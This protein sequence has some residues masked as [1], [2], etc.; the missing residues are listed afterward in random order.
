MKLHIYH[1]SLWVNSWFC[2]HKR[3]GQTGIKSRFGL[4]ALYVYLYT[5]SVLGSWAAE[6][7]CAGSW[8]LAWMDKRSVLSHVSSHHQVFSLACQRCAAVSV[9]T[10]EQLRSLRPVCWALCWQ[11]LLLGGL[12]L[13]SDSFPVHRALLLLQRALCGQHQWEGDEWGWIRLGCHLSPVSLKAFSC[14]AY[15]ID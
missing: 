10:W 4:P 8:L 15:S 11:T 9:A 7:K 14:K 12:H 2:V 6:N 13:S 5:T 1:Y 3:T